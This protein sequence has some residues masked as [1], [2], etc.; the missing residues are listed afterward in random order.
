MRRN[1]PLLLLHRLLPLLL[2]LL[3]RLQQATLHQ[4][5]WCR[6]PVRELSVH[7]ECAA[8]VPGCK[9]RTTATQ[10]TDNAHLL[11]LLCLDIKADCFC[12]SFPVAAAAAA[13]ADT[14]SGSSCQ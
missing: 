2:L 14:T 6:M 4:S 5:C 13:A 9:G 10:A 12:L 3:L 7:A 8:G 1:D 11:P